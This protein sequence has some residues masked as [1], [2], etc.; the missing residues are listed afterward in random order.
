[1]EEERRQE[2]E[3]TKRDARG[4]DVSPKKNKTEREIKDMKQ[5]RKGNKIQNG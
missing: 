1:M 5:N 3:K 2:N 4:E